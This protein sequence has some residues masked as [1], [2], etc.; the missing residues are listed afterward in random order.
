[1]VSNESGRAQAARGKIGSCS[2]APVSSSHEKKIMKKNVLVMKKKIVMLFALIVLACCV[3]EDA[4]AFYNPQ[5]GRWL[6]RDPIGQRQDNAYMYVKNNAITAYDVLGLWDTAVHRGFTT[7]W[8]IANQYPVA[9]A[10]RIGEADDDVDSLIGRRGPF[11]IGGDMSYH[12]NRN[13]SGGLDS[14]MQH[15]MD[16]MANAQYFCNIRQQSDSPERAVVELGRSLHP[17][18]DYVAHGDFNVFGEGPIIWAHNAYSPQEFPPGFVNYEVVDNPIFDAVEYLGGPPGPN[19]RPA[20]NAIHTRHVY[21]NGG[22]L[23]DFA[24]FEPGQLRIRET[25]RLTSL[26]LANFRIFVSEHGGCQC[27]RYFGITN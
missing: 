7:D 18:Q 17:L 22:M 6:R 23:V 27:R 8:A 4:F 15:F 1:M 2:C 26:W 14:R 21:D 9:A 20:G 3:Q 24:W 12:F 10:E 11:P 16:H 19:G 13:L 25:E 5:V